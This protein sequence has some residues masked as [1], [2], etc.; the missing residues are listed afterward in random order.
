MRRELGLMLA[1]AWGFFWV[2]QF[3]TATSPTMFSLARKPT[4][5]TAAIVVVPI[6]ALLLA[7]AMKP[8]GDRP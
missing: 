7:V 4:A 1:A 2:I 8:K 5:V 6:V 3:L